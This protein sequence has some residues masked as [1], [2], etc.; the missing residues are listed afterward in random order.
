QMLYPELAEG[1]DVLGD[2]AIAPG[3]QLALPVAC[4]PSPS[5]LV[6]VGPVR[7]LDTLGIAT[8]ALRFRMQRGDRLRVAFE[9]IQRE[10]RVRS[11]RVPRIAQCNR[12]PQCCGTFATDPQRRMRSLHR[13]GQ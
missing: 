11:D 6:P 7:K 10:L 9:R 4:R 12:P 5:F 8:G 3:E 13:F 2:F 1:L